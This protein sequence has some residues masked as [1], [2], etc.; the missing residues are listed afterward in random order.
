MTELLSAGDEF[1]EDSE[2]EEVYRDDGDLD[3]R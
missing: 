1:H 3:W 2:D